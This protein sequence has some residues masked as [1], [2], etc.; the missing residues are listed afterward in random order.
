PSIVMRA[1]SHAGCGPAASRTA[2]RR[3]TR[4]RSRPRTEPSRT[5]E[6][7]SRP[8]R[9]APSQKAQLSR[10]EVAHLAH[11]ARLAVTDAEL[12]LFAGQ[13]AAV[14]DAVAPVGQAAVEEVP[15]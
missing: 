12:D 1:A 10:D 9:S 2:P 6:V 14:L 15:P 11:L 3:V 13:L 7:E 4:S 8:R 5:A